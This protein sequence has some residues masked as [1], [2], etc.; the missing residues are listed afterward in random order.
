MQAQAATAEI[1]VRI[2]PDTQHASVTSV[3]MKRSKLT[4]LVCIARH[5]GKQCW[6]K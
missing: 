3:L 5:K 2:L 6:H 4:I 1:Q